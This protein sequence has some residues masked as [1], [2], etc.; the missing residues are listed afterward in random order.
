MRRH[1]IVIFAYFV[2]ALLFTDPLALHFD[3]AIPGDGFDGLQNYWNLWWVRRALLEEQTSPFF[4]RQ[5]YY[6]TG[7][8][9][10][11]HTLNI[12]NGLWSL[13][14]Q[15]LS[16]L[17]ITYNSVVLFT[18]V[19]S[20][21]GTFLLAR[22]AL[23]DRW[24]VTSGK[25]TFLSPVTCHLSSFLAGFIFAF[26]P[27]RF[28]HLLGHMQVLS[29]EWIPFFAL[30]FVQMQRSHAPLWRRALLP[31]LF[32]ALN[33]LCDWYYVLYLLI[34]AALVMWWNV[35]G[36][37]EDGRA[38]SAAVL[39]LPPS[40]VNFAAVVLIFTALSAPLLIPMLRE[41]VAASYLRPP[42]AETISLS[43][44][45]LAFVTPSEFHP[46]WGEAT[47]SIAAHFTSS[48]SE[49]TVFAGFVPMALAA[50]G[51][52]RYR[53]AGWLWLLTLFSFFVLALGP[54]LHVLGSIV[55][56]IPLPYAWLY[57]LVP[58]V[59]ITRSVSRFDVMVM[60]ALAILAA[61][62]LHALRARPKLIALCALFVG[63]EFLPIPYPLTPIAIPSFYQ[64]LKDEPGSF[65]ILELPI[66]WDRPDPLL[67]QTAHA[68]PLITAYTSRSNPLSL[69]ERTPI[70]N[71]LRTLQPDIIQYEARAIAASVL[72]DLDVRYVINHPLTMGAGDERDVTHEVLRQIFGSQKPLVNEPN[73]VIYRVPEP[74]PHQPY[75]TLGDGWG[76]VELVNGKPQRIVEQQA[77]LFVHARDNQTRV[78]RIVAHARNQF[79]RLMMWQPS[80]GGTRVMGELDAN[81]LASLDVRVTGDAAL[82]ITCSAPL[83]VD[84]LVLLEAVPAAKP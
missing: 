38:Q 9:L 43:A 35:R 61:L 34:F 81:P 79:A 66:N 54:Y 26:A 20:G 62:G 58:L 60:L 80:A 57:A 5:L 76:D 7:T 59:R 70:L 3:A 64:A 82:F 14:I 30:T 33:A 74:N 50:L 8:S 29:T 23:R 13:P 83:A 68:R 52:W 27:F 72:S 49:R 12:F 22:H 40:V 18:F 39:R 51:V 2:L 15:L 19:L 75:L 63:V 44:D 56:P 67:Y 6:P 73:L 41:G 25:H 37:T 84:S 55:T 46:W 31:A 11:F 10:L 32:L 21:Y 47:R 71:R 69:V 77:Q 53:R 17:A 45:L 1:L 4:T 65:A 36:Q 48:T 42:L 16:N 78:L 24:Q 28:A